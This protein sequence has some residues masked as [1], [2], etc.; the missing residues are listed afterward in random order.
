MI[1]MKQ[2]MQT[3]FPLVEATRSSNGRILCLCS[4]Y[5]SSSRFRLAGASC[6]DIGAPPED[7]GRI[8]FHRRSL[9][10]RWGSC[11]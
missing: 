10:T 9:W 6:V 3:K 1:V 8:S 2:S 4:L 11:S 7:W 5:I